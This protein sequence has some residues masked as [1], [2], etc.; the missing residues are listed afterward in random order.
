MKKT[1]ILAAILL[2]TNGCYA[3]CPSMNE[4]Q[5]KLQS[6]Q[7][8]AMDANYQ[9]SENL[10]NE[11]TN[12]VNSIVPGCVAYFKT[13]P[14]PDCSRVSVLGAA[15]ITMDSAKQPSAKAQIYSL[16]NSLPNICPAYVVDTLKMLVK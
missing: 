8:K 1:F 10:Y 11:M 4:Y 7:F 9:N 14:S 15:Y 6:Y 2:F 12:Y 3:A 13:T 16:M 5:G